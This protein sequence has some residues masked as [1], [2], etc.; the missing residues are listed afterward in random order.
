M[1][2]PIFG[3]HMYKRK[4]AWYQLSEEEKK[5]FLSKASQLPTKAGAKSVLNMCKAITGEWEYF[6][7]YEYPDI[8]IREKLA[9]LFE[10]MQASRYFETTLVIGKHPAEGMQLR[11]FQKPS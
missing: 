3:I 5:D 11:S 8:E 2:E 7:V 9:D 4:E 6:G 1:A 10:E